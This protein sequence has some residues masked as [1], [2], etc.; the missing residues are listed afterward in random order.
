RRRPR[1]EDRLRERLRKRLPGVDDL[2]GLAS[3]WETGALSRVAS[4]LRG[5][6]RRRFEGAR[7]P[8]RSIHS[9]S[10][11]LRGTTLLQVRD[12]AVLGELESPRP[13]VGLVSPIMGL[14]PSIAL[15]AEGVIEV[16]GA[17][18]NQRGERARIRSRFSS[19]FA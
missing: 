4:E 1:E 13:D 16:V 3:L 17:L 15:P 14:V 11:A 9:A 7:P 18:V 12:N 10:P 8:W 6:S 19:G 2:H 5:R